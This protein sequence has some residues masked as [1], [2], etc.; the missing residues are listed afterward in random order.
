M[1]APTPVRIR[2][3]SIKEARRR[4]GLCRSRLVGLLNEGTVDAIKL[5]DRRLVVVSSL[6]SFLARQRKRADRDRRVRKPPQDAA[7]DPLRREGCEG[8]GTE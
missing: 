5:F 6:E 7:S 3:V 4:S 1:R 8:V 2:L